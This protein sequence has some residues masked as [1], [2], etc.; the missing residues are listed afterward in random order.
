VGEAA[1]AVSGEHPQPGVGE[2]ITAL[3]IADH[4]KRLAPTTAGVVL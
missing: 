3:G 1:G 2:E 4:E